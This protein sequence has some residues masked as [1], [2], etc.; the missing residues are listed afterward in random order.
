MEDPVSPATPV[1]IDGS[2]DQLD[3]IERIER[4]TAV[5]A[6]NA[7]LLRRRS[8]N[9]AGLDRAAYL[10]LRT[11]DETGPAS[12][13][14]L[15]LSLGVD[16]STAGRQV[17]AAYQAGLVDRR[18]DPADRRCSIITPT[19][20]GRELMRLVHQRRK[21]SL[22]ELTADWTGEERRL[23]GRMFAK[24]NRAVARRYLTPAGPAGD[25]PPTRSITATRGG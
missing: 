8:H 3:V 23:L 13:T 9:Y 19:D 15:A 24:Y 21:N 6:R 14:T 16:A 10:L 4:E 1:M 5:L 20:R 25:D 17:A 7:E 18:A 22:A 12:I 2:R 11:L